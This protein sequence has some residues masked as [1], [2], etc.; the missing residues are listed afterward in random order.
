MN[1]MN[2]ENKAAL[3]HDRL[4]VA[5]IGTG[6]MG[7]S[8][9]GHVLSAGHEV[10]LFTRTPS[11][12]QELLDRGAAWA[13]SVAEAATGADLVCT[14][15]GYPSDVEEVVLGAAG[16]SG[17]S[18]A[19]DVMSPGAVLID[20]TSSSPD[21]ARRIAD[22]AVA[23]G[24]AALD[25]PVTGGDIGAREARLSIMVGGDP[26]A[27]ARI[28][29][30]LGLLATTVVHQG[31]AGSG[32][33]AKI[34]NQILVAASMIGVSE[35]L[36]FATSAGLD[37]E[38][39]LSSV[40]A[41]AAGSWSLANLA[42]RMLRGDFEPGFYVEHFVKDLGLALAEAERLGL[43][44]PGLELATRLYRELNDA[45]GGSSGTQVL[46]KH[47]ASLADRTFP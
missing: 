17:V 3:N 14:M 45:G 18:G 25:A 23:R 33:L 37:P 42:P 10:V 7:R 36:V 44:L 1:M 4:R 19:L 40:S 46:V 22:A 2:D 26:D 5:W 32:Q 21:L 9:A 6:V 30:I 12:A 35:A 13:S 38:R 43:E 20:F 41:G 16:R 34:V 39:V 11:K 27:F 24:V 15:V 31:P 8:M 47:I 28:E 29:P